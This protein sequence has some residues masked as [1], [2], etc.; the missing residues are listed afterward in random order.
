MPCINVITNN[1]NTNN[2]NNEKELP[3]IFVPLNPSL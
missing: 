3:T 2:N 1:N